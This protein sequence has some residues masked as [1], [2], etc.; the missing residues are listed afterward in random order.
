[1]PDD[2][3]PGGPEDAGPTKA[4]DTASVP[5]PRGPDVPLPER[6]GDYKILGK[7]GEGGMGVVYEAE[8]Q[9]PRRRVALKV[10]RG[11]QFVDDARVKM[12]Q[13]E[14][15]TLARLKH[16]NIGA[17]YES[18]RT[19]DG[20]H[21]FAM[22]LVR[23]DTLNAYMT[24]RPGA[25]APDELNFRL[26]LFR[27]IADAVHYAHQRGVIHRDLKPNNIVVTEEATSQSGDTTETDAF[28]GIRLPEI[29]I[30]DFGLARITEG[31]IAAATLTTEV[32]VI[33]GTLPYMSPEQARGNPDATAP[34]AGPAASRNAPTALF[35]V[36]RP[37]RISAIMIGRPI[38]AMHTR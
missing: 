14:A 28:G 6:I 1:M 29:K 21:F 33:K 31:D 37:I 27:K 20:Q 12:F 2:T 23:G 17:I 4:P 38:S 26:A 5:T 3:H 36:F 16:P 30:L 11:G 32:G 35:C 24:K 18:G 8:Q 15:E 10:V 13:R 7:L 34:H 19:E 9:E 25:A 22:E